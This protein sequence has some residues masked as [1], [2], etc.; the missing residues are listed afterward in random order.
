MACAFV[1]VTVANIVG[2]GG[3]REFWRYARHHSRCTARRGGKRTVLVGVLA[4][5]RTG[6]SSATPKRD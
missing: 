1:A 3:V 2:A 5:A 4:S 6:T